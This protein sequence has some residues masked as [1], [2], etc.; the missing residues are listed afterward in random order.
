MRCSCARSEQDADDA[1]AITLLLVNP[2]AV[3]DAATT[4]KD[5]TI[6]IFVR[7]SLDHD[8]QTQSERH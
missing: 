3:I 4:L 2:L 5:S 7:E 1:D 6:Y 8:V